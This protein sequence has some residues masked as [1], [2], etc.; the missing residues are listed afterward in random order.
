VTLKV[1]NLFPKSYHRILLHIILP[2]KVYRSLKSRFG[3]LLVFSNYLSPL[4]KDQPT[5]SE[6]LLLF[7]SAEERLPESIRAPAGF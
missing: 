2:I 1:A 7:S 5:H 6:G 4:L 3:H